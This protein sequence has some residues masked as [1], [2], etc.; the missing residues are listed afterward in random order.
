[1]MPTPAAAAAGR[2]RSSGLSRNA[3]R[4]ICTE[5]TPGREIADSAWS[6]VS[7]E[8][9]YDA[10]EPSSTSASSASYVASSSMTALGG[11]CSCTRSSRSVPRLRRERSTQPRKACGV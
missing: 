5:A 11:Q 7:T 10:I 3:F 1:M 2:T 4:M 9:P 8:T 6:H